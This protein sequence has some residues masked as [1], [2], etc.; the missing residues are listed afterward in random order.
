[1]ETGGNPAVFAISPFRERGGP[2]CST[3][4]TTSSPRPPTGWRQPSPSSRCSR[5]GAAE[6]DAPVLRLDGV[7]DDRLA[8]PPALRPRRLRR[9][10]ADLGAPRRPSSS[11]ETH[12]IAPAVTLKL[13]FDGEEEIGSPFFGAFTERHKDLLAADVALVTDGPKDASGRPTIA[14]GA[15]GILALELTLEA[16]RRDV[17]SGNFSVPEPGLGAR[18]RPARAPWPRRTARRCRR[19]RGRRHAADARR[20]RDA[21]GASRSTA[22]RSRRSSACRCPPSTSSGSCS[23]RR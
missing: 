5:R 23:A 20:A 14:F 2:C 15:R 7:A 13:I 18:G 16:A 10:G 19:L 21:R 17:H 11:C 4:T 1:M 12:G 22:P 9:Q 8:A 6:E 3:A